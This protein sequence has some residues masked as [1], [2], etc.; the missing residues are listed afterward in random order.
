MKVKIFDYNIDVID[1]ST[2]LEN[3]RTLLRENTFG[4]LITLNPETIIS[5][6]NNKR[7]KSIINKASIIV[8]DGIGLVWAIKKIHK[9]NINRITGIDLTTKLFGCSSFSFYFVGSKEEIINKAVKNIENTFRKVDIKG[10]SN[11]YFSTDEETILINK[12]QSSKADIILVG[13]G[14][15][16][17]ELFIQKLSTK[18]DHGIGIGIGGCFDVY[19]KEKKRAPLWLQ[20]LGLE[21]IY[22]GLKEPS[23]IIKRWQFI[24]IYIKLCF[25]EIIKNR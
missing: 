14:S 13:L 22:R 23:R 17:Q 20:K 21:W 10:Y 15:P 6:R 18:L 25:K 19:S 4:S 5:A 1:Y 11:G 8:A 3:L 7:L 24:P 9:I 16:K 2:V 12:I